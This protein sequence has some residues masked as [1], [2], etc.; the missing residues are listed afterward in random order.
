MFNLYICLIPS[1]EKCL[2]NY[3][4]L[5]F[6]LTYYLFIIKDMTW[7]KANGR[8]API[9]VLGRGMGVDDISLY[10]LFSWSLYS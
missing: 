4:V 10:V 3:L 7:D 9:K 2:F 5:V 1:R 6:F 8:G